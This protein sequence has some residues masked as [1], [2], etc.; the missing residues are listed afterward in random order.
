MK[1]DTMTNRTRR[2]VEPNF[3]DD[4]VTM[5]FVIMMISTVRHERRHILDRVQS[6]RS[7]FFDLH[8]RKVI[9]HAH[10]IH[11]GVYKR[12][13]WIFRKRVQMESRPFSTQ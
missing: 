12:L 7:L 9:A 8:E 2:N 6:F 1:L 11:H 4:D 10:R 3:Y 13:D 5:G